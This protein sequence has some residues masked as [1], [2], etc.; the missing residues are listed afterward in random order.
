MTLLEV[1]TF[2]GNVNVFLKV[3]KGDLGD[4][5]NDGFWLLWLIGLVTIWSEVQFVDI[6]IC[7]ELPGLKNIG[8][9]IGDINFALPLNPPFSELNVTRSQQL[10]ALIL[11][12]SI[13]NQASRLL[14]PNYLLSP[15]LK[16]KSSIGVVLGPSSGFTPFLQIQLLVLALVRAHETVHGGVRGA[17][18]SAGVLRRQG[19]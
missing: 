11:T 12:Q 1:S 8:W 9:V 13:I 16:I 6:E 19:Y 17:A 3:T 2:F 18:G 5:G 15:P 7:V 4:V 10:A 14:L